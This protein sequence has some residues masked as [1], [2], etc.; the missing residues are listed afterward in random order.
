[1]QGWRARTTKPHIIAVLET[2]PEASWV[3]ASSLLSEFYASAGIIFQLT[4]SAPASSLSVSFRDP[5]QSPAT[6]AYLVTLFSSSLTCGTLCTWGFHLLSRSNVTPLVKTPHK[7]KPPKWDLKLTMLK[8]SPLYSQQ[9]TN[10]GY[11]LCSLWHS[12][13]RLFRNWL[14]W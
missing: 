13:C 3:Q 8:V 5:C 14:L 4:S 6:L 7:S 2:E 10:V 9:E 11:I 12:F 1:M